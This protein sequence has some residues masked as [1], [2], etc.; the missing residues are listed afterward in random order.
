M[1]NGRTAQR[2]CC[3]DDATDRYAFEILDV[4][5]SDNQWLRLARDDA[6]PVAAAGKLTNQQLGLAFTATKTARQINVRDDAGGWCI[7]GTDGSVSGT[8]R[9]NLC[10]AIGIIPAASSVIGWHIVGSRECDGDFHAAVFAF[11]PVGGRDRA[12]VSVGDQP[13]N[14]QPEA[15]V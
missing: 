7:W 1:R 4:C 6:L 14:V 3:R 10:V 13:R 12:T 2:T 5:Q 8:V 15:Q 9:Y 11:L